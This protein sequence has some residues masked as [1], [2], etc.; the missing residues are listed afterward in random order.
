MARLKEQLDKDRSSYGNDFNA[1]KA[2]EEWYQN[3]RDDRKDPAV[4]RILGGESFESGKM[5]RFR[6]S[7][8]SKKRLEWYDK[9]PIIISLGQNI[10]KDSIVETG[11]NLNILPYDVKVFFLDRLYQSFFAHINEEISG[12]RL[13]R[14][15]L[16]KRLEITYDDISYLSN[17]FGIKFAIRNYLKRKMR[18]VYVISYENWTRMLLLDKFYFS[19]TNPRKVYSE[20]Y[21]Y[22]KK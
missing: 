14:A 7:P 20:Y 21:K 2:S 15:K 13:G 18:A 17:E 3:A 8:I 6:Y 4:E 9:Y 5:Y 16:Q 22:I 1:G 19:N 11:I 10:Y 12:S